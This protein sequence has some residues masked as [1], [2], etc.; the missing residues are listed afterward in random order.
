VQVMLRSVEIDDPQFLC[1]GRTDAEVARKLC[2]DPSDGRLR[3]SNI[4]RGRQS[5]GGSRRLL[6]SSAPPSATSTQPT[7]GIS[8]TVYGWPEILDLRR[9]GLHCTKRQSGKRS[10]LREQVG[11]H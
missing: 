9:E 5:P 1:C 7:T 3:L 2:G 6:A 11:D 4:L 10:F 8:A